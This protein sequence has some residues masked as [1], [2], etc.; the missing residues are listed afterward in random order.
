VDGVVGGLPGLVGAILVGPEYDQEPEYEY[1]YD[2]E[3]EYEYEYDQELEYD[4]E[5]EYEYD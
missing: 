3:P 4:Y 1:E 5:Y 2:Q